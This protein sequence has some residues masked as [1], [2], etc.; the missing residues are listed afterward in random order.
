MVAKTHRGVQRLI[1]DLAKNEPQL[2]EFA[3][4]LSQTYNLK[5]VA[6]YELGPGA[7]VPLDRASARLTLPSDS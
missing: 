3:R 5:A 6:D 7:E 2:G 1:S 4:F